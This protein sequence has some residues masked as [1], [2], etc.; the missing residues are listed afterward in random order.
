[1]ARALVTSVR[2][3]SPRQQQEAVPALTERERDVLALVAEGHDNGDIA[4]RLY[5]SQSTVKNHVSNVLDKLGLDNRVQ[6]AA[7]AIRSGIAAGEPPQR[8]VSDT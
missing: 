2:E 4:A 3:S 5:L 7:F 8:A 6:A 1:V